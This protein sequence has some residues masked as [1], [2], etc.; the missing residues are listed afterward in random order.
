MAKKTQEKTFPFKYNGW[1]EGC[2]DYGDIQYY[3]VEFTEDFG[4][5]KKGQKFDCVF[6]EHDKGMLQAMINNEDGSIKEDIK[7]AWKAVA[8]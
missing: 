6:V 2:G 5:I 3:D 8:R 7:V 1:D 4:P